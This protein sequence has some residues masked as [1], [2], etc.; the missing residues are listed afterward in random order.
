MVLVRI[1]VG[2]GEHQNMDQRLIRACL[3]VA[4]MATS[5]LCAAE[6]KETAPM[7]TATTWSFAGK[8]ADS[9]K[10]P[11]RQWHFTASTRDQARA[12]RIAAVMLVADDGKTPDCEIKRDGDRLL[13]RVALGEFSADIEVD[14]ST[15]HVDSEPV[16]FVDLRPDSGEAGRLAVR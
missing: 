7:A 4:S 10:L 9:A 1:E 5:S 12:R 16:L 11:A 6:N 2:N 15:D 13:A 14:I 8:H 3:V